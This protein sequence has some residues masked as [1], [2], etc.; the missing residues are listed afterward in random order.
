MTSRHSAALRRAARHAIRVA[1][2]LALACGVAQAQVAPDARYRT[3][4]TPHFRVTF[5]PDLELQARRAAAFAEH[6]HAE[7]SAALD[8]APRGTIDLIVADPVDFTN[9][10]AFIYPDNRIV[11]YAVPPV[12]GV[13]SIEFSREWMELLVAHELAHIFHHD[14]AGGIGVPLRSVFGRVPYGWPFF[15]AQLTPVW[16]IEGLATYVES[17]LTGAGRVHGAYHEMVLRTAALAGEL[18]PIDRASGTGPGWPG[19]SRSYIYG[20]MFDEWLAERLGADVH[21]RLTRA[22]AR[23]LV[24]PFLNFDRVA[25]QAL[26]RSFTDLWEEW[27]AEVTAEAVARRDSIAARGATQSKRLTHHGYHTYFPRLSPDGSL[28]AYGAQTGRESPATY[29]VP[30][31]GG[32]PRSLHRR[33]QGGN[34]IGPAAWLPDGS[35][36]ITA[37]FESADPYRSY[38]DLYRI[39]LDGSEARLTTNA[40]V[41]E[42]DVAR[43][44]RIVAVQ[45]SVGTNRL[46]LV[47]N[48]A[49]RPITGY[50]P[51]VHWAAPRWSPDGARIAAV[52]WE[53]GGAHDVVVLELAPEPAGF[54]LQTVTRDAAVD[55]APAWSHDGR[56]VLFHSERTGVPNLFAF[57]VERRALLQVSDVVTGAFQPD[58]SR[59]GRW[60]YFA[61]YDTDGFHV[62]RMAYDP[63]AWRAAAPEPPPAPVTFPADTF[64]GQA[65]EYSPWRSLAPTYW[66][67]LYVFEVD[68]GARVGQFVGAATSGRDLVGRHAYAV[69]LEYAPHDRRAQWA[70]SYDYAGLGNP[71]ISLRA[72]RDWDFAGDVL[73]ISP[74]DTTPYPVFARKDVVSAS[75]LF[76]HVRYRYRVFASVGGERVFDRSFVELPRGLRLRDPADDL[77]GVVLRT[78]FSNARFHSFS[79]SAEDG[80]AASAVA[81]QRWDLDPV[82]TDSFS[83]DAGYRE[84]FG[85][86]AAYR[87]VDLGAFA[88]HVVAARVSGLWRDG[89]GAGLS[90]IGGASGLSETTIFGDI[91]G[92]PLLLPVRGFRSGVRRGNR[93]WTASLE[94]RAPVALVQRGYRLLPFF[95][96]RVAAS[97]FVD[98][99][100]AWCDDPARSRACLGQPGDAPGETPT[101]IVGAGAELAADAT[102]FY[103]ASLF[104]RLGVGMPVVGPGGSPVLY[105]RLGR[106]F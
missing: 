2:A 94:A 52:R 105:F 93:A 13:G 18:E 15:P 96:D 75:A 85:N 16:N 45:H 89:P 1:G 29:L 31:A 27:R 48:G 34:L 17:R 57:D 99:G 72:T 102:L 69:A 71:V 92:V 28:V 30:A 68:A 35:A 41:G 56:Y 63:A 64:G 74:T 33:N 38:L 58:V 51:D 5:T 14:R 103:R 24:P 39:G 7:L 67:P 46:V 55:G 21:A 23:A 106:A 100:N 42:P 90:S 66:V 43:D 12:G 78:G 8:Y 60:I 20:S 82:V 10:L 25:S 87:G 4:E 80:V 88:R 54:L 47:E 70:A 73:V 101:P 50:D 40:R 104:A 81:R 19:G 79:I 9:G 77:A 6:A 53:R 26:G 22:T 83:F 91:G 3:I 98:A 62:E 49:I 32:A 11:L 61:A 86:A 84:A 97:A 59:D 95:L 76:Q 65:R 44:G 36:L 37:Q